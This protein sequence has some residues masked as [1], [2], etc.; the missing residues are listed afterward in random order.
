MGKN[1]S[2]VID[3]EVLTHVGEIFDPPP[4]VLAS[5]GQLALR[6]AVFVEEQGVPVE[7]ELDE[8]DAGALHLVAVDGPTVVGTCRLLRAGDALKLGRMAVAPA[9][10]RRGIAA[11]LLEEAEAHARAQGVRVIRL[12]SQL[13]ARPAYERAG[14][15]AYGERFL[16][17]GI[18][19]VMME[20]T[21]A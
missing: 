7:E 10:R 14:Y 4:L 12:S 17:A 1:K 18:E 21:L 13:E 2:D 11:R 6:R 20:K 19:H 9:A 8:H 16:D 5:P 15:T 3:S